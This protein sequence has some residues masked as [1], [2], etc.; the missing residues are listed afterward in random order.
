MFHLLSNMMKSLIILSARFPYGH[1]CN[2][3]NGYHHRDEMIKLKSRRTML[4]AYKARAIRI[5]KA[6]PNEIPKV[7]GIIYS[8]PML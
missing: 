8:R 5:T 7:R 1:I 3:L 2:I 4:G 6:S